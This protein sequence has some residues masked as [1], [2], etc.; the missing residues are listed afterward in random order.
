M[1]TGES[2][3]NPFAIDRDATRADCEIRSRP[4]RP[5]PTVG[6]GDG[7]KPKAR[8]VDLN[9]MQRRWFTQGG[10][11]FARVEHANAWGAVTVDLWGCWD[12]IAVRA[13]T[14]GVLFVQTTSAANLSARRRK[15]RAAPETAVLLAAGNRLQI[16]AWSQP[17]GPGTRWVVAVE[18]VTG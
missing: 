16:H 3:Q 11:A 5:A 15:I 12:W 8:K 4:A 18:E 17:E 14:P 1:S 13:D 7:F 9:P 6:L 2:E 10:W